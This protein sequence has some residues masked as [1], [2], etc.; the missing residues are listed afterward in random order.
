MSLSEVL[1][2]LLLRLFGIIST[3]EVRFSLKMNGGFNFIRVGKKL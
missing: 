2:L 1:G 3:A